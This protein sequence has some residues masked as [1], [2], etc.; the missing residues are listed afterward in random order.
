MTFITCLDQSSTIMNLNLSA[1]RF[2]NSA[3]NSELKVCLQWHTSSC[4]RSCRSFQQNGW[5]ASQ[6]VYL[7]KSTQLGREIRWMFMGLPHNGENLDKGYTIFLGVR[8]WSCTFIGDSDFIS[9]CCPGHKGE[10]STVTLRVRSFKWQ[11]FTISTI[12]QALSRLI[13]Q[14]LQ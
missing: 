3:T 1:K 10:V 9:T 4:Q 11:M 6:E 14:S 8:M 2:R 12:N 5:E 7:K 13:L